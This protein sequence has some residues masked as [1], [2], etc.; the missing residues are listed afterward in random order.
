MA[1]SSWSPYPPSNRTRPRFRC[2]P[3][4][5][6][7]SRQQIPRIGSRTAQNAASLA[8]LERLEQKTERA[9]RMV[10][11]L[12]RLAQR[13]LRWISPPFKPEPPS[14]AYHTEVR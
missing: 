9:G 7:E 1:R 12:Q 10:V 5:L 2:R 3:R 14:R 4:P 8:R 6:G 11:A 13:L